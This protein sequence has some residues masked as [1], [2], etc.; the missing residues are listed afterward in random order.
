MEIK[1][2]R[3]YQQFETI[4]I[5]L[6]YKMKKNLNNKQIFITHNQVD[7]ILLQLYQYIKINQMKPQLFKNIINQILVVINHN[8]NLSIYFL[9]TSLFHLI[10]TNLLINN[11]FNKFLI[12]LIKIW[13][14]L[15]SILLFIKEMI[16]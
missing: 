14:I 16:S 1:I 9:R 10:I 8:N 15:I 4:I 3:W 11:I 5:H 6:Q 13:W 12:N 2:Q 7:S